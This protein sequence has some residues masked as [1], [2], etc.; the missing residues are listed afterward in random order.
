MKWL[1]TDIGIVQIEGTDEDAVDEQCAFH[2]GG[3]RIADDSGCIAVSESLANCRLGYIGGLASYGPKCASKRVEKHP[4][5]RGDDVS[6]QSFILDGKCEFGKFLLE[7]GSL[8]L[9]L[10][11]GMR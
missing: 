1:G 2:G 8:P 10:V 11:S 7:G 5:S 4:L 9:A 6:G 3:P